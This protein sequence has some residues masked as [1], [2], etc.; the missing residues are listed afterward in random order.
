P[1]TGGSIPAG[2]LRH[3]PTALANPD[4]SLRV[5][6]RTWSAAGI[7][8]NDLPT[9]VATGGQ[10]APHIVWSYEGGQ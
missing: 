3:I 10:V 8:G 5:E 4:G 7:W 1:A 6:P 2:A 9:T